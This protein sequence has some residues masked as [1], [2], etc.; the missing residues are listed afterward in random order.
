MAIHQGELIGAFTQWAILLT[1]GII[2]IEQIG[3]DVTFLIVIIAIF[4]AAVMGGIALA[5]GLGARPLAANLIGTRYLQQQ[6]STGQTLVIG[7]DEGEVL[8]FTA[9]GIVL[10]TSEGRSTVP[11]EVYFHKKITLRGEDFVNE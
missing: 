3:I 6:Y 1:A 4:V 10:E 7:E 8:E 11:G 5:F 2:A 9:T